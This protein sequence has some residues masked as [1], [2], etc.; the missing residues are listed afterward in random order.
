MRPHCD[1]ERRYFLSVLTV[2]G[3]ASLLPHTASH[4]AA[5]ALT[6]QNFR[7]YVRDPYFVQAMARKK[8]TNFAE[9]G[10]ALPN[11]D[12]FKFIEYQRLG[13]EVLT[14]GVALDM[15]NLISDGWKVLDY[16]LKH[17]NKDGGFAGSDVGHSASLYLEALSRAMLTDPKGATKSRI[18]ALRR[19][20]VWLA[21]LRIDAE[22]RLGSA[23]FTHRKFVKAALWGQ[24]AYLCQEPLFDTMARAW[25][26]E[27]LQMGRD[28]I[29][30]EKGGFD[31]S[32]QMVAAL[33]AQRY[34]PVCTDLSL[35]QDLMRMMKAAIAEVLKRQNEDGS[36]IETDSTRIGVEPNRDGSLKSFNYREGMQALINY[37][38]LTGD[39][40]WRDHLI[41][42]IAY[43]KRPKP[44]RP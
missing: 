42:M 26:Y 30:P 19:A 10:A 1:E 17:Q 14:S 8:W 15:D 21:S 2:G 7:D 28:N 44:K 25:A 32:Y 18:E 27:G 5:A 12:E 33:F 41:R 39:E 22:T 6:P 24:A 16:G 36:M 40:T 38:I 43:D 31:V 13:V 34:V 11:K 9:N 20:M 37:M 29:Y 35:K 4:A 3:I 23:W